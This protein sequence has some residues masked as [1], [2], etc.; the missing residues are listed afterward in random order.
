MQ[1]TLKTQV[2]S[3]RQGDLLEEEM[4]THSSILAWEIHEQRSLQAEVF[5]EEAVLCLPNTHPLFLTNSV[6]SNAHS[7]KTTFPRLTYS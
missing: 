4:T 5:S 7:S 3:L 6:G 1:Q 2:Q